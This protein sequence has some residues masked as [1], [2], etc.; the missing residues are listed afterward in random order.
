[1]SRMVISNNEIQTMTITHLQ[2][3]WLNSQGGRN[4]S[5]VIVI[6]GELF[7]AMR[8]GGRWV[9]IMLPTDRQILREFYVSKSPKTLRA[10]KKAI[11]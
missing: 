9:S 6:D 5:D 1:M 10:L 8:S 7:I 4:I 2:L 11:G 3:L